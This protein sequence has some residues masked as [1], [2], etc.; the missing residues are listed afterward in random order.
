MT[1]QRDKIKDDEALRIIAWLSDLKFWAKQDDSYEQRQEGTGLWF[2]NELKFRNW[3]YG[4]TAVLW[5]PG[6]H[7]CPL[8][9]Q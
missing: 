2:L 5:C 1:E 6:S 7:I 9:K 8:S 4:D 3:V